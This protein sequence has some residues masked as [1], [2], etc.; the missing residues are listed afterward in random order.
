MKTQ[1]SFKTMFLTV[2]L[3][4]GGTFAVHAIDWSGY[5]WIGDGAGGGAYSNK[6]KVAPDGDQ[7]VVNIQHPDFA[8]APGIYTTFTGAIQSCDLGAGNY[9]VQGGG[10]VMHLTAFTAKETVVNVTTDAGGG[11]NYTF[12]VYYVDGTEGGG[13]GGDPE[14]TEIFDTNFALP[15]N[16]G[17]ASAKSGNAASLA[18]DDNT[19][20]RWWSETADMTD[21]QKDDQWW[22]VDLGQKR[23]FN[24]VQIVWE[25]AWGKSFEIQVSDDESTWTAVS[26]ITDQTI[27]GP[28]PYTQTIEFAKTTARYVR[29]QGIKRGTGYA[30]SFWEFRVYMP[31]VSVLTSITLSTASAFTPVSGAGVALTAQGKDQN[32]VN[33][34]ADISYEITPA[35]AG[36]M[37][38]NTYI[39]D[40]I[41]G[42]SIVAY[43]G[44]VRSAAI[45]VYG[46]EGSN[47]ALNK[48]T[49]ASGYDVTKNLPPSFAVDNNEGSLWSA[50]TGETGSE[51]VYDAWIIVDLG[52]FYDINL[53]AIRWEGACSKHY[54]VDFSANKEDWRTA[55]NAG[56]DAIAT[57]WEY[58]IGT[59]TD[60]TK[61][62]YVRVWSTEAISQY[63]V[64]IMDLKVFG[65]EWV[66]PADNTKPVMSTATLS[67]VTYN[68][69]TLAVTATDNV[70]VLKYHV[71]DAT[72]SINQE[73]IGS[74]SCNITIT[75]LA[76]STTYNFTVSAVDAS[77]NES[78]NSVLVENVTTAAN[79]NIPT[80]NAPTPPVRDAANVRSVYSDAYTPA[81][82]DG[83]SLNQW[84]NIPAPVA[85][86]VN[87]NN[88]LLYNT[89]TI[90]WIAWGDNGVGTAAIRG[91]DG[92][93]DGTNVGLDLR[94][95]EYMHVDIHTITAFT[96][97]EVFINDT[98]LANLSI[99][100]T[101][102]N[103]FDLSLSAF[104]EAN[105]QNV[106][107][108]KFT[109]MRAPQPEK[110]A[111][112]NVY[113]YKGAS[114]DPT[115]LDNLSSEQPAQKILRNG[116]IYILRDGKTYNVLGAQVE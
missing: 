44:E 20:T 24:T 23:I 82:E 65:T 41:G 93:T 50:R 115:S 17:T 95:M 19:D 83:F 84:S 25:G 78:D 9:D 101:G 71:V 36:H 7:G 29:F 90:D 28:F 61:V 22:Q 26:T 91:K 18:N 99:T 2:A 112:D 3:I 60:N 57:H 11:K 111:I 92:Y 85:M 56:W 38:G 97:G 104:T 79:P 76:S 102:W 105:L 68:S 113:F 15:A 94:D 27:S 75:G 37:S 74:E 114:V 13:G 96:A 66:S 49:E 100:E 59:E 5:E 52:G 110:I 67:S 70:A 39:P 30:Y 89:S 54:H 53:I 45:L 64:K 58:L 62:R 63:G 10:M 86:E 34:A 81:V 12:T 8:T 47:V 80:V 116:N 55:Y 40:Q 69:A 87:G 88:M 14:P 77:D 33:M 4:L 48:E 21:A 107:W 35:A 16:G 31:N 51:R 109:G 43:S 1:H 73:I 6:Y 98:K 108:L 106:R 103:S 46:Y 72:N 42:A 32:N